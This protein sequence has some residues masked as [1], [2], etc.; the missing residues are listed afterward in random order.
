[1]NTYSRLRCW[2]FDFQIKMEQGQ[3]F[4]TAALAYDRTGHLREINFVGRGKIGQ[5]VDQMLH[6]LG[7]QLSRA[8]QGRDP[9]GDPTV[10]PLPPI[11]F[12]KG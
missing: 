9:G 11:G 6:E 3:H 7:I 8:I 5:G 2:N 10:P 1:M 12:S 4:V